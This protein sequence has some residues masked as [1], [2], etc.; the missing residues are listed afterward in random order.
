M[1]PVKKVSHGL[2]DDAGHPH[3][4][5]LKVADTR[6]GLK[7]MSNFLSLFNQFWYLRSCLTTGRKGSVTVK[8]PPAPAISLPPPAPALALV[9]LAALHQMLSHIQ[10]ILPMQLRLSPGQLI[11]FTLALFAK[12]TSVSSLAIWF[13][14]VYEAKY[15][16]HVSR[17]D[18]QNIHSIS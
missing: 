2:L 18:K 8:Q 15:W 13:R 10:H 12:P 5:S 7:N 4:A 11:S 3:S 17:L 6:A 1:L 14:V 16:N 9:A